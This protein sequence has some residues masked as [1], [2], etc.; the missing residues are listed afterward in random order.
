MSTKSKLPA[1][2]EGTD[3]NQPDLVKSFGDFGLLTK[4]QISDLYIE[5]HATVDSKQFQASE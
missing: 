2:K 5:V 4:H 3:K 1:E